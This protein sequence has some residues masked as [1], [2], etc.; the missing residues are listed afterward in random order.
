[1][2]AA[3][4]SDSISDRLS[5]SAWAFSRR[6]WRFVM[7]GMLALLHVV[8]LRGVADEGARALVIAHLG[9]LLL[10]Q[11][12]LRGER[13]VTATQTMFIVLCAAAAVLWLNWW[14]LAVWIVVLAGLVGGR[15]FLHQARWQRRFYLLVFVYLFALLVVL[16]LPEIAPGREIDPQ[17][18]AFAAWGLPALFVLMALLPVEADAPETAQVIDYFYSVFLM[19]M[20]GVVILGSFA[21]MTLGR[22]GYLEALTYIVF[23]IGGALLAIGLAWDPRTGYAGFNV[24]VSRY[25]FSIGLP[26]E[27]WLQVL[28]GLSHAEA[29]PDRYLIQA[30]AALAQLPSV[31]GVSWKAGGGQG[32]AGSRTP[33]AVEF[34]DEDLKLTIYS[35][36]RTTPALHGHL[37]LL[38]QLLAEFYLAKLREQALREASFMQAVHETGARVTHDVKNLLQSLNVLCSVALADRG[39]SPE[40]L[41][42]LRRQLPAITQRLAAT[43]DKLQRPAVEGEQRVPAAQWWERLTRQYQDRGVAFSAGALDGIEV[44][45]ALFD[46]VADNLLQNALAKRA[47][48]PGVRVS[49]ALSAAGTLP[50]LRVCDT[51]RAVPAEIAAS[52]LRAPVPS[53]NGLGIGLYQAARQAQMG[54]Y[55]LS[56]EANR[57]GEVCF[58]LRGA[59]T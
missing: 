46:S 43:L 44:P 55:E 28:A 29:R 32:E 42:L 24:F 1:M 7:I 34:G 10:W 21:F 41:A 30:V 17:V 13:P 50:E 48:Q 35:R 6:N 45:H 57:D 52:L 11:P 2:Q 15:V 36:Y 3:A 49:A 18:R 59:A 27:K 40:S 47:A 56:L 9:L 22:T 14:L 54:G 26:I 38:G 31:Q 58:A 33:Y 4:P 51:G 8:A 25:L 19:L 16:V 39:E 12:I 37:R 20:L 5:R 53:H 23:V